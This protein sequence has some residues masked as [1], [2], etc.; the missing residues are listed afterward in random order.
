MRVSIAELSSES[1]VSLRE[2]SDLRLK[3][4]SGELDGVGWQARRNLLTSGLS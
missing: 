2:P 3:L 4:G 1:R